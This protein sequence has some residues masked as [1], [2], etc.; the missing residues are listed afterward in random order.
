[1][2]P[3]QT[4]YAGCHFRSRLE[5]R[6]AVFFDKLGIRWEYEPQGFELPS[7]RRYL[8]DFW[9]PDSH[10][11]FE[12][13]GPKPDP[14]TI[15]LLLEFADNLPT[16]S[17][18]DKQLNLG[19]FLEGSQ[20][21]KVAVGDIPRS[22]GDAIPPLMFGHQ[23][24]R[25]EAMDELSR[26]NPWSEGCI[27]RVLPGIEAKA[28]RWCKCYRGHLWVGWGWCWRCMADNG[29]RGVQSDRYEFD[30]HSGIS[31]GIDD[32]NDALTAARSARFE[33]QGV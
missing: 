28:T 30:C 10:A 8:P 32:L 26:T 17:L 24:Q 13:K 29:G 33:R 5:A 12:V 2:K 31:Y 15:T 23:M 27:W 20:Y 21:L 6:W 4:R 25:L 14:D 16:G 19:R 18:E 1:M 9:L 3:I 7:G 22:Y 11:W